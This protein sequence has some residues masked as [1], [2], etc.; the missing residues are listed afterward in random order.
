M[1]SLRCLRPHAHTPTPLPLHVHLT[2]AHTL[3]PSP[4]QPRTATPW[5][6]GH[7]PSLAGHGV[8]VRGCTGLGSS[9]C[10][11]QGLPRM[12]D[13]GS[14]GRHASL[15]VAGTIFHNANY[16]NAIGAPDEGAVRN[17]RLVTTYPS[18]YGRIRP[19]YAIHPCNSVRAKVPMAIG[20][21]LSGS[22]WY[23]TIL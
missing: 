13:R 23:L 17:H 15:N 22:R 3:A 21:S 18:R 11:E 16:A 2:P 12:R 6:A 14:P 7:R 8:A 1:G 20:F 4:V 9:D 5:P 19:R 10:E